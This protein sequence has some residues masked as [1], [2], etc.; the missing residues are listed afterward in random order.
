MARATGEF[1]ITSWNEDTYKELEGGAKLTRA[2]VT[3]GFTGDIEGE[4]AVEW[5]MCYSPEGTARFVG[6]QRVEGST[7]GRGG[8]FVVECAGDFDGGQA[9]GNWKV[10]PGSATGDLA[11][12]GGTDAFQAP[13]GSKASYNLDYE[14]A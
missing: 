4:G 7:G 5:L 11:G 2:S 14:L 1:K 3:Q 10:V 12:L 8:S 13:L 9:T 6:L